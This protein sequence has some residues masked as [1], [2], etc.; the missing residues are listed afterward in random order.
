MLKLKVLIIDDEVDYCRILENYFKRR[1]YE[2]FLSFVLKDG[3]N[4]LDQLKP[5]ILIL[6]NNLPDG[7]G[8]GHVDSIVEKNPHLRIFLISA[9]H[10]KSDPLITKSNV[11]IWEK[12]L[13]MTLLNE[14]FLD[15]K[16]NKIEN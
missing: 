12:P 15:G 14:I 4:Q 10:Q 3:L 11:T 8:W 13:S 6:D 9:Y 2:V 5:D 7:K 1:N 16:L